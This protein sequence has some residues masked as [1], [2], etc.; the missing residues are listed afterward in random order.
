MQA[1]LPR[2][3][4]RST[5]TSLPQPPPRGGAEKDAG[6]PRS[7]P[8]LAVLGGCARG[9]DSSARSHLAGGKEMRSGSRGFPGLKMQGRCPNS[10]V[11]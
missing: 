4:A 3:G 11:A 10:V 5:V 7:R 8:S 1:A 9:R 2:G 6:C